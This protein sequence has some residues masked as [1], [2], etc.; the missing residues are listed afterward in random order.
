[1]LPDLRAAVFD[2][3]GT[4]VDNMRYHTHA[5]VALTKRLGISVAPEVFEREFAGKKNDEILPVLLGRP[6]VGAELAALAHEKE[7]A[8]RD[9]YR[10][11]LEAMPGLTGFLARL[12]RARVATAVATAAP[13]E[14]RALVLDGL[15]LTA[16]FAHVI[17]AEHAARGKPSPDIYLAA[18]R[19]LALAPGAC[20]AFEDAVNGV[21]SARAAGMVAVGVLTTTSRAALLEAGAAWVV[22]DFTALPGE[23]VTRLGLEE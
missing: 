13:P 9:L 4:L 5:W 15:G 6:V 8:Y 19:A 2:M 12:A 1:L 18:A 17:G 11:R 16:S 21:L 3:D 10:P 22:A 23:L 20:V 7:T 14:N